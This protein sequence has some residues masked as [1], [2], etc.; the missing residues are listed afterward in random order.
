MAVDVSLAIMR[1]LESKSE[2]TALV[3]NKIYANRLPQNAETPSIVLWVVT[4]TPHMHLEGAVGMDQALF[5]FDSNAKTQ[6]Q[7]N[8]LAWTIWTVLDGFQG[9]SDSVEIK[10]VDRSSGLRYGTDRVEAGSD[11]YRF[12]TSQDL[13]ITYCSKE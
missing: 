9:I 3:G 10:G 8:E 12:V 11:Q 13:L 1:L 2:I 6:W 7:A 5:Q 4:E